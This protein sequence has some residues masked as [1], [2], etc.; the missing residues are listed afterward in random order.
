MTA[1]AMTG[2]WAGWPHVSAALQALA[3]ADGFQAIAE[4]ANSAIFASVAV[5]MQMSVM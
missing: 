3:C 1:L 5:A 2:S 4:A